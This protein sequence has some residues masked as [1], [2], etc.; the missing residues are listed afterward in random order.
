MTRAELL[1]AFIEGFH[2]KPVTFGVDD[3]APFAA[4]WIEYATGRK[5]H[6][7]AYDSREGGQELIRRAGGLVE[8]CEPCLAESD[9]FERFGVPRLGDVGVLRT[10]QFGDVGGVFGAGGCFFWRHAEGTAVLCPRQRY[11]LKVWALPEE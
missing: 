6:L 8:V 10:S 4:L 2:G 11:V 5:V 1:K 9:V 3:C 7:P